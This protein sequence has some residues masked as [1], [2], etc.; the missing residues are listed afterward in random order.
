MRT[1]KYETN[2]ARQESYRKR[3]QEEI[4]LKQRLEKS[5]RKPAKF[6]TVEDIVA[7]SYPQFTKEELQKGYDKMI[8]IFKK[9]GWKEEDEYPEWYNMGYEEETP[10]TK[11]ITL[12]EMEQIND[13]E[14]S[15]NY[16]VRH[17][18]W[19]STFSQG[20]PI[21]RGKKSVQVK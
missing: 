16:C 15:R 18:F 4:D 14:E 1:R 17:D 13:C 10:L 7:K 9:L 8:E 11:N 2:A 19:Y 12:G 20:C 21:C 3:K 6:Y 5:N